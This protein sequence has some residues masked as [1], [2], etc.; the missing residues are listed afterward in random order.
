MS[1]CS[2]LTGSVPSEGLTLIS[3]SAVERALCSVT[4]PGPWFPT[5]QPGA[6]VTEMPD[7]SSIPSA[8]VS[9]ATGWLTAAV[10][11][12][13]AVA[14][15]AMATGRTPRPAHPQ[16]R[17]CCVGAGVQLGGRIDVVVARGVDKAC[18]A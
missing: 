18:I 14:A 3:I 1:P 11:T 17:G 5:V 13:A 7:A 10:R 12:I 8:A 9:V 2:T 6:G 15:T 4:Q 16:P